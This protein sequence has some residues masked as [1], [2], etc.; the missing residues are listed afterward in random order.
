MSAPAVAF[1]EL[2]AATRDAAS[3]MPPE[4]LAGN[5]SAPAE[6]GDSATMT[7]PATISGQSRAC[8]SERITES[9]RTVV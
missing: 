9:S 4:Q 3:P 8:M 6:S 5:V 2:I 7:A 1:A